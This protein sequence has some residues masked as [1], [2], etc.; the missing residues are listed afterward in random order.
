MLIHSSDKPFE[1]DVCHASFNRKDKLKRHLLIHDPIKRYKC[2]LRSCTGTNT[3]AISTVTTA[4][5]LL[6]LAAA[7]SESRSI[8]IPSDVLFLL[9]LE[10]YGSADFYSLQLDNSST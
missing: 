6:L 5:E 10:Y 2:P 7:C 9:L 4:T 1:C 8:V 3:A